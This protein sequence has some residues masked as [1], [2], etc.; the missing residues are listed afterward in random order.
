MQ[1]KEICRI[2]QKHCSSMERTQTGIIEIRKRKGAGESIRAVHKDYPYIKRH[3]FSNVW[4]G[5]TYKDIKC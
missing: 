3:T 5:R 2:I 1:W 4:Y